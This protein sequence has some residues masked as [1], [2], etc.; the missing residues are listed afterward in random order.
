MRDAFQV[1]DKDGNGFIDVKEFKEVMTTIGEPFFSF[2]FLTPLSPIFLSL[3]FFLFLFS[4]FSF[5]L[6]FFF[7]FS[8]LSLFFFPSS[9]LAP[10]S[11]IITPLAFLKIMFYL[12][13]TPLSPMAFFPHYIFHFSFVIFFIFVCLID[14][15]GCC[16]CFRLFLF[17]NFPLLY[18][19]GKHSGN[20][21]ND[22]R[23]CSKR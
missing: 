1:F 11:P 10:F 23:N 7:L 9:F 13:L 6:N 8:F 14:L 5:K 22:R 18:L 16:C 2:S 12:F 4:F 19:F 17:F 20:D 15:R 3:F 21:N